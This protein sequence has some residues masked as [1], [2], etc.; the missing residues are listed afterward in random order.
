MG[1]YDAEVGWYRPKKQPMAALIEE[2]ARIKAKEKRDAKGLRQL[3]G[4]EGPG[5][6]KSKGPSSSRSKSGRGP[7]D[8]KNTEPDDHD[9]AILYTDQGRQSPEGRRVGRDRRWREARE[10]ERRALAAK[11][12]RDELHGEPDGTVDTEDTS[13]LDDVHKALLKR[14]HERS[15]RHNR[16]RREG[17]AGADKTTSGDHR[18]REDAE[19]LEAEHLEAEHFEAERK[20]EDAVE[21]ERKHE[22]K[23]RDKGS[24]YA[25]A[26]LPAPV[27]S[28]KPSG[29]YTPAVTSAPPTV[30]HHKHDGTAASSS[31]EVSRSKRHVDTSTEPINVVHK[32]VGTDEKNSLKPDA[33][34]QSDESDH[35]TRINDL[36]SQLDESQKEKARLE[37]E[38]AAAN[39]R[40]Q[41]TAAPDVIPLFQASM[42]QPKS[43]VRRPRSKTRSPYSPITK[44]RSYGPREILSIRYRRISDLER[45]IASLKEA[46]NE[47]GTSV[48][49]YAEKAREIEALQIKLKGAEE[50]LE[51]E[52]Q[53]AEKL[54]HELSDSA[55]SIQD[56][57]KEAKE[58]K[59]T[60]SANE[61]VIISQKSTLYLLNDAKSSDEKEKERI[62]KEL[63]KARSSLDEASRK[64]EDLTKSIGDVQAK[65]LDAEAKRLK[66]EAKILEAEAKTLEAEAKAKAS[67]SDAETA[68]Q[69]VEAMRSEAATLRSEADELRDSAKKAE[70]EA[71]NAKTQISA[72][73]NR[74]REAEKASREAEQASRDAADKAKKLE[75][76]IKEN[77]ARANELE[78]Q[79]AKEQ[80]AHATEL[81]KKTADTQKT[82]EDLKTQV[83]ELKSQLEKTSN[84][85][86]L[87]KKSVAHLTSQLN[88]AEQEL[89]KAKEYSE[90]AIQ[91][92]K[93]NALRF[94]ENL[95]A[96]LEK[97]E[98]ASSELKIKMSKTNA[99]MENRLK[100]AESQKRK[101]GKAILL[102]NNKISKRNETIKKLNADLK[103]RIAGISKVQFKDIQ[104]Y[105]T[106]VSVVFMAISAAFAFVRNYL[107]FEQYVTFTV[108]AGMMMALIAWLVQRAG[109]TPQPQ[110]SMNAVTGAWSLSSSTWSMMMLG[111]VLAGASQVNMLNI[112]NAT[113]MSSWPIDMTKPVMYL[114]QSYFK[115]GE[116]Y[117]AIEPWIT[118]LHDHIFTKLQTALGIAL[119]T[120]DHEASEP[121][122]TNLL[123]IE[124]AK[125]QTVTHDI[126]GS[127]TKRHDS[128]PSVT[129]A[130]A[131]STASTASTSSTA[132]T[133]HEAGTG[134]PMASPTPE[135]AVT[136]ATANREK[137]KPETARN[138]D[139][140]HSI[141]AGGEKHL[142]GNYTD[143]TTTPIL[144]TADT[145]NTADH[146]SAVSSET[147]PAAATQLAS[148]ASPASTVAGHPDTTNS[149]TPQARRPS[150]IK[151]TKRMQAADDVKK[152]N[153]NGTSTSETTDTENPP[154]VPEPATKA[155]EGEK[156]DTSTTSVGGSQDTHVA[157]NP[158]DST[159]G[160]PTD[161][162]VVTSK[163]KCAF[164]KE[165]EKTVEL[166]RAI[167]K[168]MEHD[169]VVRVADAADRLRLARGKTGYKV[170][171]DML[172]REQLIN[173][174]LL[175]GKIVSPGDIEENKV[176]GLWYGHTVTVPEDHADRNSVWN[177]LRDRGLKTLGKHSRN[178]DEYDQNLDAILSAAA[179]QIRNELKHNI[180]SSVKSMDATRASIL[181][182]N[183]PTLIKKYT[184]LQERTCSDPS[185]I[186]ELVKLENLCNRRLYSTNTESTKSITGNAYLSDNLHKHLAFKSPNSLD[187]SDKTDHSKLPDRPE[188][189]N[190]LGT[191][192]NARSRMELASLFLQELAKK[193]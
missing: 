183:L 49:E 27:H 69:Q 34:T 114:S 36:K 86:N 19:H 110:E 116:L 189:C 77:E 150:S 95:L 179:P 132:P 82:V 106:Y 22:A 107:Q 9:A 67:K 18:K 97:L 130:P 159:T 87:D 170:N 33:G 156:Q 90:R 125:G 166:I 112:D 191:Q 181:R 80:A 59:T 124:Q 145:A 79:L 42:E 172:T 50:S 177:D 164:L 44:R 119:S 104:P 94:A 3:E 20:R 149:P 1:Q 56:L 7:N 89:G 186:D 142:A 127:G 81:A 60:L 43:T 28:M 185:D 96:D 118:D 168:P 180:Q 58:L 48:E 187:E 30:I 64:E 6:V 190:T 17:R 144:G 73:E 76:Q 26:T 137:V 129:V 88:H 121:Q 184:C 75:E 23:S 53:S 15:G 47:K 136:P 63:D 122:T 12:K 31:S 41:V 65:I 99:Q 193:K 45:T 72:A 29:N 108:F 54:Q 68:K 115:V 57:K 13:I 91:Q 11:A 140:G 74:S 175:R 4:P 102:K 70:V 85:R 93:Q 51:S 133:A 165:K 174:A 61:A 78:E 105:M 52:K 157:A 155:P 146:T 138:G 158:S 169:D 5:K 178:K 111:A 135:A 84:E 147:E 39:A 117:S 123:K 152:Q 62:R 37:N 21:A 120:Y 182:S 188:E 139:P 83:S 103:E 163:T 16:D 143:A 176:P 66:A 171:Q 141:A 128:G 71:E 173:Y 101:R 35:E 38:L 109:P 148:S 151:R 113:G 40:T 8:L 160:T 10:N 153:A 100:S 46:R 14:K 162:P 24:T 161:H 134:T 55:K 167:F 154:T 126:M 92:E 98:A 2:A 131:A 192:F 32:S 25:S